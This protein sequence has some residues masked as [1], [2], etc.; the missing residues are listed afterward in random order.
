[1]RNLICER[2]FVNTL[3]ADKKHSLRSSE[4]LLQ[5]FQIKLSTTQESFSAFFTAFLKFA[6]KFQP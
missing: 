4:K 2:L 1:M 5:P 6:S 3:T